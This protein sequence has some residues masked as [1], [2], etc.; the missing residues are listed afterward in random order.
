M[1][2][3]ATLLHSMLSSYHPVILAVICCITLGGRAVTAQ[4]SE[5]FGCDPE[6]LIVKKGE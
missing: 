3:K 1:Y 4:S 5:L 6:Y 2:E